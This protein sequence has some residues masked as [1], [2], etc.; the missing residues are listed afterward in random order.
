MQEPKTAQGRD[1]V[2]KTEGAMQKLGG[3]S[4]LKDPIFDGFGVTFWENT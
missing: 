4:T 1:N 2:L 3:Q